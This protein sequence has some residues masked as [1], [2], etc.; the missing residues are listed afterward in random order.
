MESYS[1]E[2]TAH[3]AIQEAETIDFARLFVCE[4]P[5]MR[6]LRLDSVVC[7][8]LAHTA[9]VLAVSLSLSP[10][11][12]P[13][14]C[15]EAGRARRG[16]RGTCAFYLRLPPPQYPSDSM[17]RQHKNAQRIN[18][19]LFFF[20]RLEIDTVDPNVL[21]VCPAVRCCPLHLLRAFSAGSCAINSS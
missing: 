10:S 12:A 5:V 6:L 11:L 4:T 16:T 14:S 2:L 21:F 17:K 15:S 13:G 1:K 7:E 8:W 3:K 9:G 18:Q 19:M 20:L